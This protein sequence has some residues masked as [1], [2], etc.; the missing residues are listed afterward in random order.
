MKLSP[1][2][3]DFL[4]SI[5]NEVILVLCACYFYFGRHSSTGDENIFKTTN[6]YSEDQYPIYFICDP[7]HLLKTIRN[8]FASSTRNL[9]VSSFCV[10]I[11]D[12]LLYSFYFKVTLLSECWCSHWFVLDTEIEI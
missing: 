1:G 11:Y 3:H 8:C 2:Y 5:I 6:V 10:S 12:H 9:W 7:P 4:K